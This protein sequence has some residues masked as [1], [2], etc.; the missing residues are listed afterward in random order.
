MFTQS[1]P[2]TK[3]AYIRE[4]KPPHGCNGVFFLL[5]MSRPLHHWVTASTQQLT[6]GVHTATTV[7]RWLMAEIRENWQVTAACWIPQLCILKIQKIGY[8]DLSQRIILPQAK[9]AQ[10]GGHHT[11]GLA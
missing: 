10:A 1:L 6:A 11:L 3:H 2:N 5:S 7:S 4:F 8:R 9:G